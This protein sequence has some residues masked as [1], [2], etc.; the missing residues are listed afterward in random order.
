[1]NHKV[2]DHPHIERPFFKGTEPVTFDKHGRLHERKSGLVGTVKSLHMAHL[3]EAVLFVGQLDERI[4]FLNG[5]GDRFLDEEM[6][7]FIKT[8]FCNGVVLLGL[9]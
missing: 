6:N 3:N 7:P 2:Q 4:R 5:G 1:M 8:S 9:L